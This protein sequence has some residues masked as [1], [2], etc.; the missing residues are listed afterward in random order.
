M[1]PITESTSEHTTLTDRER[2]ALIRTVYGEARG[3]TQE[4]KEAVIAV[5]LNRND[6]TQ[7]D[8]DVYDIVHDAVQ[9]SAWN[10]DDP[11]RQVMIGL[12]RDS[13]AYQDIGELVDALDSGAVPRPTN[14][15]NFYSPRNMDPPYSEPR[16]WDQ[17]IARQAGQAVTI[18]TQE[19]LEPSLA[20]ASRIG[21]ISEAAAET[22]M[23]AAEAAAELFGPEVADNIGTDSRRSDGSRPAYIPAG[24]SGGS[25]FTSP[26]DGC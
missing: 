21:I 24:T 8:G 18:G 22:A 4:G 13:Q 16:W 14:A 12:A 25:G 6:S 19:F 11:N 9:F 3:E 1:P 17:A 7:Y 23:A 15:I 2:D 10:A 26:V 5:V 20:F